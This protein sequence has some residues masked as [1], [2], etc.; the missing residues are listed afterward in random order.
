MVKK[1]QAGIVIGM[2]LLLQGCVSTIV[3]TTS[4]VVVNAVTLPFKA[5]AAIVRAVIPDDDDK[6][7]GKTKNTL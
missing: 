6:K 5:G 2:F 3:D 7:N 4:T 1:N